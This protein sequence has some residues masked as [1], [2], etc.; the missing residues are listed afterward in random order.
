MAIIEGNENLKQYEFTDNNLKAGV[1]YYRLKIKDE[2]GMISYSNVVSVFNGKHRTLLTVLSPA[3]VSNSVMLTVSTDSDQ[4]LDL[5]IFDMQGRVVKKQ[6]QRVND[7]N[8]VINLP[9][10][11]FQRGIYYVCLTND[12]GFRSITGFI[13]Q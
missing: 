2:N 4:Q 1:N 10:N 13:K 9:V 12:Q 11:G 5:I 3:I 7:G 8:T 6:Y